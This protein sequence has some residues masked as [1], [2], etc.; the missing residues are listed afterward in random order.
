MSAIAFPAYDFY[1]TEKDWVIAM[2]S[3]LALELGVIVPVTEDVK[4]WANKVEAVLESANFAIPS[5]IGDIHS[6]A[7]D[8]IVALEEQT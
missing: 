8:L 2:N 5:F 3:V 4:I 7:N 1:D 6:W